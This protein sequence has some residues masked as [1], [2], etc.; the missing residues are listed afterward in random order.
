MTIISKRAPRWLISLGMLAL[1]L[2]PPTSAAPSAALGYTPKYPAGFS[3]F[4]YVNPKAPKG[5][6]LT[7]DGRGT[8]DSFNPFILR[9][10][11]AAGLEAL[12]FE[13][14]MVQSLDEPFSAY[15]H[16]AE[17]VVLAPDQRSVTFRLNPRARFSNGKPVTAADVKFSFDTLVSKEAHPQR[18]FYYS[19]VKQVVVVDQR[20]VRFDFKRPNPEL[21]LIIAN[22]VPIFSREWL[23]NKP[24]D[25]VA[26][27]QPIASGP[28]VIDSYRLGKHITYKRNPNYWAR[29]LG[30][31]RGMFNFDRVTFTYFK[32]DTAQ[33]EGFKAG[34]FDFNHEY[35]AKRWARQYH[36]PQFVPGKIVKTELTHRNNA[37]MQ[38]FLFNIRRP[39]FQDRRV[40]RAITLA[41]DFEWSNQH[42]FYGQYTRCNS[43]FSNSEMASTGLPQGEELALLERFRDKLPPDVFTTVWQP[44]ST[45]APHSLRDN[46]KQAQTLLAQAGWK[47]KDGVLR[48]AK[49]QAFEF[50]ILQHSLQGRSFERILAP[51][52]RNLAKLGIGMTYRTVDVTIYQRRTD[53]FDFDM[54]VHG[55]GQSQSPGNELYQRWHSSSAKQEGSD[56]VIGIQD[57]GIDAL[58]EQVIYSAHDR[59]KLV[60][61]VRALDRVM[62]HHE[63]LVPN[64]YNKAH[65]VAYWEK[66]GIPAQAPLYYNPDAWV[67]MSWW[68]K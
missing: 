22:D 32:D 37:G 8:F 4:D 33:F 36:G 28:Y 53:T 49:G 47:V 56:N 50:E 45:A 62:L 27:E 42:L 40:R 68:S 34:E 51:F 10:V 26:L 35:S 67:L 1:L 21:H 15:A 60:T 66:F 46:L 63:F 18:R 3:H 23:A 58:I 12:V 25:K 9:G 29:D 64:W 65:R 5:G 57:P 2:S 38:G 52:Q 7:L 16:L 19:D 59:K 13:T 24:F 41:F 14:L 39:M 30:T 17:D 11:A 61:A 48:N 54:I 20:T 43:Y 44:P 31:R 55:Y 6:T